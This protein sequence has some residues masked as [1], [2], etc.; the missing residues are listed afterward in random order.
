MD[1]PCWGEVRTCLDVATPWID[2]L[3][4]G[5][6]TIE[7]REYALPSQHVGE[8]VALLDDSGAARG[9]PALLL[10]TVSFG[11]PFR[12]TS[13]EQWCADTS[14]HLV[15]V[16]AGVDRFGWSDDVQKWGWPVKA[17]KRAYYP[18]AAPPMARV[19]RS[20]FKL[21]RQP[22][23]RVFC[24]PDFHDR[25][26]AVREAL[27][28]ATEGAASLLVLADFDRTLSAYAAPQDT[29][30]STTSISEDSAIDVTVE[31]GEECHDVI[32]HHANL[33]DGF[34]RA[35]APLMLAADGDKEAQTPQD[36]AALLNANAS[37]DSEQLSFYDWEQYAT[38][39]WTTAHDAMIKHGL[40][41][42]EIARA[43]GRARVAMRKGTKTLV[44][45]CAETA[46]PLVVVSAG[47]TDVIDALMVAHV[48]PTLWPST[49][50]RQKLALTSFDAQPHSSKIESSLPPVVVH[51]NFGVFAAENTAPCGDGAYP[52]QNESLVGFSP[53]PPIHWLNKIL[54]TRPLAKSLRFGNKVVVL[55]GD[56]VKDVTM[57]EGLAE[58]D[59]PLAVLKIGL[60]NTTTCDC[61]NE[62]LME[63][64]AV[65]DA[66][67]AGDGPLDFVISDVLGKLW[68]WH[69]PDHGTT[70]SKRASVAP[71]L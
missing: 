62:E 27:G 29:S 19:F 71:R 54:T 7:T 8:A 16:D 70:L 3:L 68:N 42:P 37:D 53:T 21:Q 55:L 10:G 34:K 40:T 2:A 52:N 63:H 44:Q 41:K 31:A 58:E 23:G 67:I 51:A 48:G 46:T 60:L 22:T 57:V 59:V 30:A 24:Q 61:P 17:T 65:F 18:L 47:I 69:P 38:W 33:G 6:K 39:W 50:E 14:R 43:V 26:A 20:L 15:P 64:M 13:R 5:A 35:V 66:V 11:P 36:V 56:S 25:L 49:V 4:S 32:F 9:L 1:D 45:G 12:Y 28:T